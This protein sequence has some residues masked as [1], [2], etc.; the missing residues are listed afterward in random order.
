MKF[1]H[2]D[3]FLTYDQDIQEVLKDCLPKLPDD[4]AEDL[5]CYMNNLL[6]DTK[7]LTDE[8]QEKIDYIKNSYHNKKYVF[9]LL[10]E[11]LENVD[12]LKEIFGVK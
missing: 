12:D 10:K 6:L 5:E 4:W 8:I 9:D 1:N 11:I 7:H 3:M 2:N